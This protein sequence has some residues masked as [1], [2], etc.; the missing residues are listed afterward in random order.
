MSRIGYREDFQAGAAVS[1]QRHLLHHKNIGRTDQRS[2]LAQYRRKG[3]VTMRASLL[4]AAQLTSLAMQTAATVVIGQAKI[5][6]IGRTTQSVDRVTLMGTSAAAAIIKAEAVRTDSIL[7]PGT[8]AVFVRQ[9][10]TQRAGQALLLA[11]LV[12]AVLAYAAS[13]LIGAKTL[14]AIF[15]LGPGQ[16][17]VGIGLATP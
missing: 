16:T 3:S 8:A 5:E 12:A 2:H 17:T 7:S 9:A 1:H 10:S 11:R 6:L 14:G 4:A 15:K 13:D